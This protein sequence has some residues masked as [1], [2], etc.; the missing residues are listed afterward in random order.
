MTRRT[1][2]PTLS[3]WLAVAPWVALPLFSMS[4]AHELT[5]AYARRFGLGMARKG[6][7]S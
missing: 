6:S 3:D 2:T 4:C 7:A 5:G 1:L